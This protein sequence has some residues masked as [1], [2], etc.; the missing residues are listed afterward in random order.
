MSARRVKLRGLLGR[1][2]RRDA[3]RAGPAFAVRLAVSFAAALVVVGVL[4]YAFMSRQLL[5]SQIA[6]FAAIQR[7]N[8]KTF[9]SYGKSS[10]THALATF[11]ID[12]VLDSIQRQDGTREAYL[13][14]PNGTVV[15]S[16]IEDSVGTRRTDARIAAALRHGESYAGHEGDGGRNSAHFEFVVPVNLHGAR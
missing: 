3:D 8:A 5:S 11:R 12:Q 1:G 4:G 9:E 16:G 15:A 7:S 14:S 2:R 6:S 13:I 10:K